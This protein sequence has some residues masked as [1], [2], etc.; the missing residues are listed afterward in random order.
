MDAFS[1]AARCAL[2]DGL[3]FVDV[4]KGRQRG[5][6]HSEVYRAARRLAAGAGFSVTLNLVRLV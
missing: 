2:N 5:C 4:P 6:A 3:G 1:A